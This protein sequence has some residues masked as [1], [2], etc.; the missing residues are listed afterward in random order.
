MGALCT[1]SA[2]SVPKGDQI[3]SVPSTQDISGSQ[4]VSGNQD[5]SGAP[6]NQED[7]SSDVSSSDVSSLDISGLD[8]SGSITVSYDTLIQLAMTTIES[9][10]DTSISIQDPSGSTSNITRNIEQYKEHV[11]IAEKL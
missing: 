7:P 8:V 4:D 3:E 10:P 5:V 6:V 11:G 9:I 1:T 2:V